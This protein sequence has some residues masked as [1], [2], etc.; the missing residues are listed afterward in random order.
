M[1]IN[2]FNYENVYTLS[3]G[4]P[5]QMGILNVNIIYYDKYYGIIGFDDLNNMHWRLFE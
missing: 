1:I 2:N 4:N 5:N 3:S